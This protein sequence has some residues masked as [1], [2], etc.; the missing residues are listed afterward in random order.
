MRPRSGLS[1]ALAL[2]L[3]HGCGKFF[4]ETCDVPCPIPIAAVAGFPRVEREPVTFRVVSTLHVGETVTIC[5]FAD[6]PCNPV[7]RVD[8]Q[9]TNPAVARVSSPSVPLTVC[10]D[11]YAHSRGGGPLWAGELV[12]LSPGITNISGNAIGYDGT[13]L[14]VGEAVYCAFPENGCMDINFVRV[15][16]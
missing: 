10:N 1:A 7:A 5:A 4:E 16:P 13:K 12:G 3:L 15:V 8:W 11:A 2:G 9:S 6:C 14:G